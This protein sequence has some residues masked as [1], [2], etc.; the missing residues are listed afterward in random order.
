MNNFFKKNNK[1]FT[2]VETL[3]AIGILSLSILGTFT[4]VSGG[5]R[6]SIY[7]KDQIIAF[8]LTQ[9]AMEFIKNNRDSNNIRNL[10]GQSTNWLSGLVVTSGGASGP[11]DYGKVCTIDSYANTIT[12]CGGGT[13]TCPV[14]NQ[15]TTT[16]FYSY[17][18]GSGWSATSFNRE[19][20]F[21]SVALNSNE[22]LVTIK[23]SWTTEGTTRSFQISESLYNKQ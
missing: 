8:Y 23:T 9:E 7:A 13:G 16:G 18:T 15:N 2:L 14:L 17:T 4:A 10:S 6:S 1:G 3:V 20:S 21:S 11:C 19:I 12:N 5:L 22:V